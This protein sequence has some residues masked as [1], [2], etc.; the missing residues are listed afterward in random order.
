MVQISKEEAEILRLGCK[1]QRITKTKNRYYVE[2]TYSTRRRLREIRGDKANVRQPVYQRGEN[3]A[4]NQSGIPGRQQGN[5]DHVRLDT[6]DKETRSRHN[7]SAAPGTRR[8]N[9][10]NCTDGIGEH[11]SDVA[12]HKHRHSGRRMVSDT[13]EVHSKR[14]DRSDAHH[15]REGY[16]VS[17]LRTRRRKP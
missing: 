5:A 1:S 9:A 15:S 2:D 10:A 11:Q 4:R 14:Q 8:D 16:A 6:V 12:S 17:G 7:D 13:A 3:A